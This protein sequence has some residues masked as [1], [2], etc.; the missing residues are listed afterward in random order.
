MSGTMKTMILVMAS[1]VGSSALAESAADWSASFGQGRAASYLL[2]SPVKNPAVLVAGAGRERPTDGA[3]AALRKALASG[4][5]LV[6]DSR[7]LGAIEDLDDAAIVKRAASLPVDVVVV[8]RVFASDRG[9]DSAVVTFFAKS[10]NVL[11]AF[12]V[13]AGAGAPTRSEQNGSGVS[14]EAA[15][16]VSAVLTN[17]NE[18]AAPEDHRSPAQKEFD[19]KFIGFYETAPQKSTSELFHS[20]CPYQGTAHSPLCGPHFYEAVGHDELA[21]SSRHR[22]GARVGLIT[23]GVLLLVAGSATAIAGGV[24]G[25]ASPFCI[26][27]NASGTCLAQDT[28]PNYTVMGTGLGLVGLGLTGIIVGAVLNPNPT[29][30]RDVYRMAKEHNQALRQRLGL[31]PG[32]D[33]IPAM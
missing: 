16:A 23:T 28:G 31:S 6:M 4:A 20:A 12:N 5:R 33:H 11:S 9:K 13:E 21:Q 26:A 29:P 2:A 27:Q 15:N 18:A 7:A 10:G 22:S 17:H 30:I 14:T 3:V 32:E 24:S 1:L 8:V 25:V 19:S